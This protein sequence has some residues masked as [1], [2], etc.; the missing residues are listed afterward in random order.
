M[1][2]LRRALLCGR[3]AGMEDL[4]QILRAAIALFII[5]DP[6]GLIPVFMAVTHDATSHERRSIL[7][8]AVSS[9]SS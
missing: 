8:Q 3:I 9:R 1:T 6:I 4:G 2:C 5:I 7:N